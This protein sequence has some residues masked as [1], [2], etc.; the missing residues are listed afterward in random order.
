MVA[1]PPTRFPL[2]H[3]SGDSDKYAVFALLNVTAGDT[4]DLSEHFTV[5]KRGTLLG[6]TVAA[7]VSASVSG[8]VVTIPAGANQDAAVLTVYGV[9]SS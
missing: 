7:A 9:S 1:L 3:A 8:T 4:V 5:V 6:V 2:R